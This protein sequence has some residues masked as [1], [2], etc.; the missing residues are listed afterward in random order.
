MKTL[1]L[2]ID[3]KQKKFFLKNPISKKQ[4]VIFPAL[5]I[6]NIF[7]LLVLGLLELIDVV[8]QWTAGPLGTLRFPFKMEII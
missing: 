6:L 4:N 7:D 5:P 3:K 2:C 1:S 8:Y